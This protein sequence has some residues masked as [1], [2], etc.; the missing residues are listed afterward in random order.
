MKNKRSSITTAGTTLARP[1]PK[2]KNA[3]VKAKSARRR[4]AQNHISITPHGIY[5]SGGWVIP[6]V[7]ALGVA[8]GFA[9][10]RATSRRLPAVAPPSHR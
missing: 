8:G 5:V 3:R 7:A 6:V 10:H 4:T 1:R 9:V 2:K